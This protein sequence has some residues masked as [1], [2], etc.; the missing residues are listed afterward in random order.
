FAGRCDDEH[1]SRKGVPASIQDTLAI[2]VKRPNLACGRIHHDELRRLPG[3]MLASAG[4]GPTGREN[5]KMAPCGSFGVAH[6]RPPCASTMERLIA[7]PMPMPPALVL[8]NALNI[9]SRGFAARPT[10][11]S[12]TATLT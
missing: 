1:V 8:K 10:P 3:A 9:C 5:W 11:V 2:V 6:S 12:S 7:S 4:A